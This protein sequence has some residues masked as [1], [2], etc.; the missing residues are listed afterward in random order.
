MGER[1]D[2][3]RA[4]RDRC[5]ERLRRA[6]DERDALAGKLTEQAEQLELQRDAR[7]AAWATV[8][9]WRDLYETREAKLETERRQ[10]DALIK[11]EVDRLS[12]RALRPRGRP[13]SWSAD[14]EVE[15]E[16][17]H[18][19][20]ASVRTISAELRA[21]KTQVHRV[22]SR[23][24]RRQAEAVERARLVAIAD[25]RSPEQL[26]ARGAER[27]AAARPIEEGFDP[28][29]AERGLDWLRNLPDD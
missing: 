26:T 19:A 15:V 9:R 21:S 2:Q 1:I 28:V 10:R 24:R 8:E 14:S 25:G 22:I 7:D 11:L 17:R 29:R 6:E 13:P 27:A 20:G 18:R 5:R 23:V 12:G 3:L 16:R 4:D